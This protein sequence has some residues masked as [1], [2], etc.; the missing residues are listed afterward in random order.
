M[1]KGQLWATSD[2]G[3]V[4]QVLMSG[5]KVIYLGDPVSIN[6]Y[7]RDKFV[8]ATSLTPDYQTMALQVDGDE[9]GF[10]YMYAS[11]LNSKAAMEMFSVI[12]ACL[13]K[14]TS[15][16][17]YLPPESAGLNFVQYLL[18]FI[19]YNFGIRTQTKSTQF[20]FNTNFAGKVIELLYLNNLVSAQEFLINS[21]TLDENSLRKL[22]AE[23][24]PMVLD[25]RDINQIIEWFSKYKDALLSTDKPLV[26]GIQYAGKDSD[27]GCY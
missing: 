21:E 26:N 22:V 14:G 24:H 2:M 23:L 5:V 1:L 11:S 6:P 17:F 18:Q 8:V 25:P 13:Y 9:Q 3:L 15:I 19:E 20:S 27:Y 7:Y 4:D 10:A 16:M 12:L